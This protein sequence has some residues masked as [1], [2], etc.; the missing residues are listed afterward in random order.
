MFVLR[1]S[2]CEIH[3]NIHKVCYLKL[4]YSLTLW[5]CE[6]KPAAAF[7]LNSSIFGIPWDVPVE[8]GPGLRLSSLL[9]ELFITFLHQ[10]TTYTLQN[11]NIRKN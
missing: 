5:L 8:P 4:E 3:I 2:F 11:S 7:S 1:L 10:Q 9:T 6:M